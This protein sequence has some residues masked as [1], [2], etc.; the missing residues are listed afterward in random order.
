[1][2][3]VIDF[4]SKAVI[5]STMSV[6]D[7]E[8]LVGEGLMYDELVSTK[9]LCAGDDKIVEACEVLLAVQHK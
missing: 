8:R 4:K 9:E 1:M 5:A 6:E 7:A 2:S 3:E